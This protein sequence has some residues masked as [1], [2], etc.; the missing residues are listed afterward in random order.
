MR[1]TISPSFLQRALLLL[2]L[3][4]ILLSAF[5]FILFSA[6]RVSAGSCAEDAGNLLKNGSMAPANPNIDGVSM[7]WHAF[8]VGSTAP[9]FENADNEGYD[10]G[11]SQYIYR[12]FN[13]WDAGIYQTVANLV[14]G[15]TYHFWLVWGQALHD[16]SGSN[17]RATLINRQIGV[18]VEGGTNPTAASVR[19]SVPYFGGG[20]FNRPEWHL[21]F[22]ATKATATFFLR[23]Q[24]GHPDYRNKVFFD[25]AC[26]YPASGAPTSTPWLPTGL[27]PTETPIP[28]NTPIPN[29]VNDTSSGIH[30][31]GAWLQGGDPLASDSTYHYA[32]GKKGASVSFSYD[33]VG[34]EI[35]IWYAGYKNRG[36]AKVLVDGVK[37]GVLD[38]YSKKLNYRQSQTFGNFAPGAH[39]LKVKS[40]SAKNA[41]AT[42]TYI[43]LD[44]LQVSAL[45][46]SVPIAKNITQR[47][48]M[49]PAPKKKSVSPTPTPR[50]RRARPFDLADPPAPTP[51]DPSVIWDTRLPGLNVSLEPASVVAGSVYWKLIRA[52]YEDGFQSGG[53]HNMYFIVTNEQGAPVANQQVTQD[54]SEDS[55]STST[56]DDGTADIAMWANY[57]PQYGPG[58]YSGYVAGLPSDIVR[59]MGLPGNNHVNFILYFQKTVKQGSGPPTSTASPTAPATA[60]PTA[61]PTQTATR[62]PS[63]TATAAPSVTGTPTRTATP[64]S[65]TAA[66]SPTRTKTP[67]PTP[68][69]SLYVD[70]NDQRITYR[71]AWNADD[72][73]QARGGT[74]HYGR[75]VRGK[76]VLTTHRFAGTELTFYYI[77]F[78]NRGKARVV[79]DGVK[80]AVLDQYSPNLKYGLSYTLH[81][82]AP[83][84]HTLKLKNAG[85]KNRAAIGSIIVLDALESK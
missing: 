47:V 73:S 16:V 42:D 38:Q 37:V 63:L 85:S 58:P 77:G 4:A 40:N 57:W 51:E 35:T 55:A 19:W 75:G 65:P 69:N 29:A 67:L 45:T 23:A 26:L 68:I 80:V 81:N 5:T 56:R 18:D 66:P 31:R 34:T 36:K 21:Y 61:T 64:Q 78:K 76:A 7:H 14:P 24:N 3:V 52:D 8:V 30:Y 22:T 32:R 44:A 11:G 70:D 20:G 59:G 15:K 83:G 60:S 6:P 49:T 74:L 43:I 17:A 13:T 12:D 41:N 79:I 10:P 28:A 27:P 33:F 72:D 71:G 46:A 25:T 84:A 50:L 54:W 39:T 9:R 53:K 48:T 2:T 1:T 62:K 82:L